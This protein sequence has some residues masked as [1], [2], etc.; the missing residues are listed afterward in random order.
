MVLIFFFLKFRKFVFQKRPLCRRTYVVAR[1][2]CRLNNLYLLYLYAWLYY[3]DVIF[4]IFLDQRVMFCYYIKVK[5]TPRS[6]TVGVTGLMRSLTVRE[7]AGETA[8]IRLGVH[9][10]TGM[11]VMKL[12]GFLAQIF[13]NLFTITT[14]GRPHTGTCYPMSTQ[15]N[16]YS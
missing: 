9:P 14:V 5:V 13:I 16:T 6:E 8:E 12:Q 11:R 4:L 1:W 7:A 3:I 2:V 15:F 10:N